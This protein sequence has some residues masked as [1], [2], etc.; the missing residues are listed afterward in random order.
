MSLLAEF[1]PYLAGAAGIVSVF[2][3]GRTN[4]K[5]TEQLKME[6]ADRKN[7][8]E[9]KERVDETLRDL[10]ADDRPVDDRLREKGRL[11]D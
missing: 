5:K 9:I 7:A 4:G 1:W 10:N 8:T 2:L 11:R 3:F 6:R